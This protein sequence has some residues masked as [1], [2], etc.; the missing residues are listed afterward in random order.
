MAFQIDHV[1]CRVNDLE[2]AGADLQRRYG[3][4]SVPG[5]RHPGWGTANRIVPLGLSYLELIAVVDPAEAAGDRTGR[6]W[7]NR[8]DEPEGPLLVCLSTD[9][10][11]A[12]AAR[13]GVEVEAKSRV[14][15]DGAVVGWRSAGLEIALERPWLPFF[16]SWEVPPEL[17]PG[18]TPGAD[19]GALAWV[20]IGAAPGELAGWLGGG[21]ETLPIRLGGPPRVNAVGV[22]LG[23]REVVLT[24]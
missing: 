1:V 19:P 13:L 22:A 9:D 20:Q 14:R 10:I 23:G 21:G 5:G 18:R 6:R 24:G 11:D 8:L 17:H 4:V 15:P 16:I 3:L 7:L 2:T 12:V